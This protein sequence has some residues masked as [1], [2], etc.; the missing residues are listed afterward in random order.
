MGANH[1]ELLERPSTS[2][3]VLDDGSPRIVGGRDE[4][5]GDMARRQRV[6]CLCRADQRTAGRGQGSVQT[7]PGRIALELAR[8]ATAAEAVNALLSGYRP[9]EYNGRGSLSAIERRCISSTSPVRAKVAV[10]LPPGIHVLKNRALGETSPRSIWCGGSSTRRRPGGRRGGRRLSARPGRPPKPRG[11]GAAERSQL[12]APR[13][14][15]HK[16]VVHRPRAVLERG[17]ASRLGSRR[18]SVHDCVRGRQRPLDAPG[19]VSVSPGRG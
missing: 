15:R 19:P 11:P 2:V 3:T 8:H 6:R 17:C 12:C 16:L 18:P 9:A 1:D 4:L 10:E 14:L 13:D 5:S 7:L